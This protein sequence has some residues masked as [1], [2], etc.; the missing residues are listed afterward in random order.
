MIDQYA[1][2]LSFLFWKL[3]YLC[4]FSFLVHVP[5]HTTPLRVLVSA[6][7]PFAQVPCRTWIIRGAS[8]EAWPY[9]LLLACEL[10][11]LVVVL[12]GGGGG[13]SASP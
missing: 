2:L 12:L 13:V 1:D 7:Q 8:P 3:G 6:H 4:V 11:H 10:C 9:C 5:F